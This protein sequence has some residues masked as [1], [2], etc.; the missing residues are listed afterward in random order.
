M[1][2]YLNTVYLTNRL[3]RIRQRSQPLLLP[4]FSFSVA[5]LKTTSKPTTIAKK[6]APS[7]RAAVIIM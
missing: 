2:D 7:T 1:I 6:A 3:K 4:D 5:Y